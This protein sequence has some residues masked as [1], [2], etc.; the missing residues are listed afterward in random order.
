MKNAHKQLKKSYEDLAASA[1]S[2]LTDAMPL[3][4]KMPSMQANKL[5]H[6]LDDDFM[7]RLGIDKFDEEVLSFN[8]DLS[9]EEEEKKVSPMKDFFQPQGVKAD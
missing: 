9:N 3:P 8:L 4:L 1:F 2:E 7:E 6:H 5:Q